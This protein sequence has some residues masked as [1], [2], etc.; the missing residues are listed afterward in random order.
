MNLKRYLKDFPLLAKAKT[1]IYLDSAASSL[2][3]AVVIEKI[4]E[5]YEQYGVNIFRGIYKISEK[6][7]QEYEK[8]REAVARFINGRPEEVIFTRNTTESLNLLAYSLVYNQLKPGDEIAVSIMEHHANFVPWQQLALKRGARLKIIDIDDNGYLKTP[9]KSI[10]KK[11]KVLA[12]T[13]VSNVL[14]TIN[15]IKEIIKRAKKINPGTITIIDGAQAVPHLKVDVR[16]LGCDFLAFSSHKMLGPTGV[17]ILWGRK[18]ALDELSPFNYGGEMIKEVYPDRTIFEDIPYKFE[19]GTPD[20]AGVIAF[21]A[22][23]EYLEKVGMEKI[24]NHE[25]ELTGY[26]LKRLTEEFKS[27]LKVFGPK[28]TKD[29][30]GVIAFAF[31]DFHGH[32]IA[33]IL[34]D[35]NICVR[36]GHHCAMPL[37]Q[38]LGLASS[39][40]ASFYLYN[41]ENDVEKLIKGLKKVRKILG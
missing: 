39:A 34:A 30:G 26:A 11:T 3:P 19:A 13:Y 6:A 25:M 29:R 37:H 2:K 41:D 16:D 17:G 33:Q 20:I 12:L 40:R 36:A 14:G 7:T 8:T 18:E 1:L 31:Q 9:E 22:A 38:R 4:K 35:E 27:E 32:D 24:R 5:Y 23:I 28:N 15:P 21:R 10:T